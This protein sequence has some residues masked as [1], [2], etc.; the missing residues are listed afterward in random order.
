MHSSV[1]AGDVIYS[2]LLVHFSAAFGALST[3]VIIKHVCDRHECQYQKT[4]TDGYI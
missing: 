1:A 2:L 4:V 3:V